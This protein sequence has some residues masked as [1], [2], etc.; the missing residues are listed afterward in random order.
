MMPLREPAT[1]LDERNKAP[2][3]SVDNAAEAFLRRERLSAAR[4]VTRPSA[5]K[6]K[7]HPRPGKGL[8][9]LTVAPGGCPTAAPRDWGVGASVAQRPSGI[10]RNGALWRLFFFSAEKKTRRPRRWNSAPDHRQ[11][12]LNRLLWP[13]IVSPIAPT[14]SA[15]RRPGCLSAD[16]TS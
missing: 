9:R 2:G 15:C 10:V 5:L 7:D 12:P 11:N 8:T 13:M 3:L 4:A 16:D 6:K 14:P 1:S